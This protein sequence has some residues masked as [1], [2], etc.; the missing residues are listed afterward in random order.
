MLNLLANLTNLVSLDLGNN[1]IKDIEALGSLTNLTYLSLR[2][3]NI[4]DIGSLVNL[5][6]LE[7]LYLENNSI[8]DISPLEPLTKLKNLYLQ[9]NLIEDISTLVKISNNGGLGND[10]DNYG[11]KYY[12]RIDLTNNLLSLSQEEQDV[13]DIQSLMDNGAN[14]SFNPQRE[15]VK[16]S[17]VGLYPENLSLSLNQSYSLNAEC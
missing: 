10:E 2:G 8:S 7:T 6:N 16:V 13:K 4:E 11:N 9:Y 12:S 1:N 15:L 17:G 5:V 14:V 3:N